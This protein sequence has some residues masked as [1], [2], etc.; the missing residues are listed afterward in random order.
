MKL[1]IGDKVRFLNEVGEGRVSGIKN[2]NIVLVEMEDGFEIPFP[3]KDLVPIHTELIVDKDK[4][5]L[6]LDPEANLLEAIYMIL[7]PDHELTQ[8]VNEYRIYLYN[9]SSYHLLY[10]YAV[11]DDQHC[12]IIKQ[13]EAGPYQKIVLKIVKPDFLKNY[14]HHCFDAIFYK[15]TFYKGQMPLSQKLIISDE[16]LGKSQMIHHDEFQRPV[17]A[18]L[19]KEDFKD[20]D[21]HF[22]ELN[23]E[24][25]QKLLNVKEYRADKKASRSKKDYLQGL[26]KEVDLHIEELVDSL[27]GLSKHDMLTIQLKRF[28]KELDKAMENHYRKIVFI[29]GVGNGRLKT[30]IQSILKTIKNITFHDAPYKQY[31]YGATQVNLTHY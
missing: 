9:A 7:E 28:E 16:G 26:E 12:Q 17:Y 30:E 25:I 2:K 14:H 1:R 18:F 31:G 23:E 4:E 6:E 13:G 27:A 21:R 10:T 19:L 3:E 22:Q 11:K 24:E 20:Q 29:H 8:L 15:N 5:N